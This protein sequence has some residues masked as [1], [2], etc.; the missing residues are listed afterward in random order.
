MRRRE[1]VTSERD[2]RR[3]HLTSWVARATEDGCLFSFSISF[4]QCL[5]CNINKSLVYNVF[6][7][8]PINLGARPG[9]EWTSTRYIL[10]AKQ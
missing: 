9:Y 6:I 7:D 10:S 2:M 3:K 4:C 1:L 5:M 8:I